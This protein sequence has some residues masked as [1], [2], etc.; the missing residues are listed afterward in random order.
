MNVRR[1][2]ISDITAQTGLAIVDAILRGERDPAALAK[3]RNER[4]KA[5]EEE[6]IAKSLVGDYRVE[7]LFTLRQ[8]LTAYRSYKK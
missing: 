7:H 8:S 4:N 2:H 3:L 5:S 1:H 6:V